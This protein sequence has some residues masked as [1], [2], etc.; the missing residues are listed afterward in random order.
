MDQGGLPLRNYFDA[1]SSCF[2]GGV[3]RT[4][5]RPDEFVD[6]LAMVGILGNPHR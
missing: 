4:V 3:E 1:I 5:G 2:L 6:V